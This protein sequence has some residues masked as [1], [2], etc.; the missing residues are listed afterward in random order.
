M[1]EAFDTLKN[2]LTKRVHENEEDEYDLF[3]KMLA[4]KLRKLPEQERELFMYEIDGMFINRMRRSNPLLIPTTSYTRTSSMYRPNRLSPFRT[5][6][7][8]STFAAFNN[9]NRPPSNFSSDSEPPYPTTY[10]SRHR[11]RSEG[12]INTNISEEVNEESGNSLTEA[13][14]MALGHNK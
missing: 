7:S 5:P 12:A 3:A 13:Y 4:K 1:K 11:H 6:L 8:D 9:L 2:V 10:V 14:L